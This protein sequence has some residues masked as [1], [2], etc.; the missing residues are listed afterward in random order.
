MLIL[1]TPQNIC[2][3]EAYNTQKAV[4]V[5]AC[6]DVSFVGLHLEADTA[7]YYRR[8]TKFDLENAFGKSIALL[9]ISPSDL[10]GSF[11]GTFSSQADDTCIIQSTIAHYS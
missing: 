11:S 7:Q 1:D 2:Q 9:I 5:R 8:V 6:I 4:Y 3:Y 10:C